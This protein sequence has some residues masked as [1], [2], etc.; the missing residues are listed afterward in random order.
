MPRDVSLS[1]SKCWRT[2]G[3]N[4][5]RYGGKWS[6][7]AGRGGATAG[8]SAGTAVLRR[9]RPRRGAPALAPSKEN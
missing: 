2:V 4:G 9:G 3:K 6:P 7:P 1:D 8:L 5:L